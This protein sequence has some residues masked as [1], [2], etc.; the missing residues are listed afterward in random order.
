MEPSAKKFYI[1]VKSVTERT[2]KFE[3][4][5]DMLVQDLKVLI[6]RREGIPANE[7]WLSYAGKLLRDDRTLSSCGITKSSTV[8]ALV[9]ILGGD[10]GNLI[11]STPAVIHPPQSFD[12]IRVSVVVQGGME[13]YEVGF[14]YVVNSLMGMIRTRK[15]IPV[16]RQTLFFGGVQLK[17]FSTFQDY[18]ISNES[19]VTLMVKPTKLKRY[20]RRLRNWVNEKFGRAGSTKN[21]KIFIG[22]VQFRLIV[23]YLQYRR[24]VVRGGDILTIFYL[25]LHRNIAIEYIS[26][27]ESHFLPHLKPNDASVFPSNYPLETRTWTTPMEQNSQLQQDMGT[28]TDVFPVVV[29]SYKRSD[30][31]Y[32]T[33]NML[34]RDLKVLI[35]HK[36]GRPVE[37]QSLSFVQASATDVKY[38][39]GCC[40]DYGERILQDYRSLSSYRITQGSTIQ[41]LIMSISHQ[42]PALWGRKPPRIHT[43][44]VNPIRV[45]VITYNVRHAYEIGSPYIINSLMGMISTKQGISLNRQKLFYQGAQ[46]KEF[47]TLQDYGIQDG[48]AILLEVQPSPF[49]QFIS[50]ALGL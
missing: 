19:K 46:L 28:T 8:T 16:D 10:V 42:G 45:T 47:S 36:Q 5:G 22:I 49:T 18:K 11:Q 12:P 41:L 3:I 17:E 31:H 50:R 43:K 13:E 6:E 21:Q 24:T 39:R 14:P 4:S 48:V 33:D 7:H 1:F 9:S 30:T 20:K 38:P 2:I 25:S 40:V 34:V 37:E 29:A 27:V 44:P 32:V 15:G 23:E 26:R 35:W